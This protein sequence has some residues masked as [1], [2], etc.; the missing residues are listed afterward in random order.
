MPGSSHPAVSGPLRCTA[1]VS[2]LL[3]ACTGAG[4]ADAGA[5]RLLLERFFAASR[6]LDRTDLARYAT[7]V[8]EPTTDGIVVRFRILSSAAGGAVA[9]T[10]VPDDLRRRIVELSLVDPTSPAPP[11]VD[12]ALFTRRVSAAATVRSPAGDVSQ[13]TLEVTLQRAVAAGAGSRR[14]R[15][16]VTEV[17]ARD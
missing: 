2:V 6:L 15:W 4:C 16:I 13:R 1:L 8:F 7:T 11:P 3:W 17:R 5:E 10:A 9:P 14:G 12:A